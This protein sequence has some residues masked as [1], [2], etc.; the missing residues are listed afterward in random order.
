MKLKAL[1]IAIV[2]TASFT[3][4][5][6]PA[7]TTTTPPDGKMTLYYEDGSIKSVKEYKDGQPIGTWTIW[8][9]DGKVQGKIVFQVVSSEK[10]KS[11]TGKFTSAIVDAE[12]RYPNENNSIRFK[13]ISFHLD[14]QVT[15]IDGDT[16]H[17]PTWTHM[18]NYF[19]EDGTVTG[20]DETIAYE[21][22]DSLTGFVHTMPW[23]F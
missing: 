22:E 9:K 1:I 17:F 6:E 15:Q 14:K 8:Y 23:G 5:A 7:A 20:T 12:S 21:L 19:D 18:I 11:K 16:I 13:G 3:I 10:I 4:Q 2:A